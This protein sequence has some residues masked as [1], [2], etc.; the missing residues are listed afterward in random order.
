MLGCGFIVFRFIFTQYAAQIFCFLSRIQHR[1]YKRQLYKFIQKIPAYT[2]HFAF[3]ALDAA[4]HFFVSHIECSGHY[5]SIHANYEI[6]FGI[7][8]A[9]HKQVDGLYYFHHL[10]GRAAVQI[11]Y[12]NN[13]RLLMI[14]QQIQHQFYIFIYLMKNTQLLFVIGRLC[15][16]GKAFGDALPV[17]FQ[18]GHYAI[19]HRHTARHKAKEGKARPIFSKCKI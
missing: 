5:F 3:I 18:V 14:D 10:R 19:K 15:K 12:K 1:Y 9:T 17:G 2:S 16:V 6:A 11:I 8:I 4:F 7:E 13:G